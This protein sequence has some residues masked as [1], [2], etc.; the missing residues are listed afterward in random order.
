MKLPENPPNIKKLTSDRNIVND[1]SKL[2]FNNKDFKTLVDKY[3]TQYLYWSELKYRDM[4]KEYNLETVWLTIKTLRKFNLKKIKLS[5]I[6]NFEFEYS[7]LDYMQKKLHEFDIN[8]GGPLKDQT[9]GII[10]EDEKVKSL[11]SSTMEEAIASSILEGAVTTRKKAKEMLRK[12]RKP[13]DVNDQM[14]LNNYQTMI[15]IQRLK[16]TRLTPDILLAIHELMTKDTL[17][18]PK[19]E[20]SLRDSNE[21]SLSDGINYEIAYKPPDYKLIPNILDEFCKFANDDSKPHFIHPIIKACI[22]HFLIGYLH[23]FI[24]GNGRTA[25]AIFY[26]YVISKGYWLFEYLSISRKI[27]ESP[28]KYARAYL[29][30]EKDDNDLTYFIKYHIEVIEKALEDLREYIKK[31]SREKDRIFKLLESKKYDL[32]SR[33]VEIIKRLNTHPKETVT[34]NEIQTI[35]NIVYET[36]R[37]D[38]MDLVKIGFLEKASIRGKKLLFIRSDNFDKLLKG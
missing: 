19:Y 21:Y 18:D 7:I 20:G 6:K 12:S 15:H 27:A 14:I 3:N 25:R 24:D 37:T 31:Q 17:S 5:D 26:W 16:N 29:Y 10:P 34:I 22:L 4:P 28:A 38:I 30:T 1:F 2:F 8:L 35:F 11:V 23:P 32:N 33:Q 13:K 36:A 9:L